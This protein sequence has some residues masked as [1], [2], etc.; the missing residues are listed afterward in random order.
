M[1]KKFIR[2]DSV[3]YSKLGKKRKKLQKWRK[4]KGRDSKMRLSRKSYPSSPTVGHKSQNK[5]TQTLVQNVNDLKKVN[6]DT[7]IILA[8]VGAK[9]KLEIIKQAQ[10]S[11][12]KLLNVKENKK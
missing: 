10:E 1:K 7:I 4:P 5:K 12:I 9:K 11:K 6:K 2:R 3:R 8:K